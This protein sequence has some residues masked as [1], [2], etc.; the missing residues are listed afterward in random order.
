[1]LLKTILLLSSFAL[2]YDIREVK[3]NK[4]ELELNDFNLIFVYADNDNL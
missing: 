2:E 3:K 4:E 1:M